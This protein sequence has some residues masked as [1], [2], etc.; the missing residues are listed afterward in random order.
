MTNSR[1]T[2][3][4]TYK[5]R[6]NVIQDEGGMT[7]SITYDFHYTDECYYDSLV[8]DNTGT[9]QTTMAYEIAS[10]GSTASSTWSSQVKP[11][12]SRCLTDMIGYVE[13]EIA[14]SWVII[15]DNVN[16][17]ATSDKPSWLTISQDSSVSDG[18]KIKLV[19]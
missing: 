15:W 11:S 14:G 7:K 2:P 18:I 3:F 19:V 12:K 9:I 6:V 4:A 16:A 5:F 13:M 1:A 10:S 17:S 8:R